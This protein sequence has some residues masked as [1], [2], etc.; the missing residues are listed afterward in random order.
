M[1]MFMPEHHE[2]IEE[3]YNNM[4]FRNHHLC[5]EWSTKTPLGHIKQKRRSTDT[6]RTSSILNMPIRTSQGD[7]KQDDTDRDNRLKALLKYRCQ[8]DSEIRVEKDQID[9]NEKVKQLKIVEADLKKQKKDVEMEKIRQKTESER[10]Q[11]WNEELSELKQS[12]LFDN[13]KNN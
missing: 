1:K 3:Q 2:T 12:F 6:P 11:E 7:Q 5:L 10:L 4:K 9:I 8:L 13:N